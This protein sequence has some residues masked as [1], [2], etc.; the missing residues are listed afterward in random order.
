MAGS[1]LDN[2]HTNKLLHYP[3]GSKMAAA[4][5]VSQAMVLYSTTGCHLCEN[6]QQLI[7]SVLGNPVPEVD[8]ADNEKLMANYAEH[9]PVLHR[10]DS[11]AE[12]R[13]PFV[14]EDI[15]RLCRLDP[16]DSIDLF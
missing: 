5:S 12:I 3:W 2:Q 1:G 8:I 16:F 10:L 13:W 4:N 14:A 11:G 6:A 9:I 15:Q 7:T